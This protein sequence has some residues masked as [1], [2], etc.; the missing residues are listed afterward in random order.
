MKRMVLG[1]LCSALAMM[2]CQ[3]GGKV[4]GLT[5]ESVLAQ[6]SSFFQT[7]E[8]V[9]TGEVDAGPTVTMDELFDDFFFNYAGSCKMQMKRTN[10]PLHLSAFGT[11][12]A[13][14]EDEWQYEDFF[15]NDDAYTVF[16]NR[17]EDMELMDDTGR[18]SVEVQLIDATDSVLTTFHFDRQDGQWKLTRKTLSELMAMPM[19]GFYSFYRDFVAD[20]TFQRRSIARPLHYITYDEGEDD[21]SDKYIEGTL[22]PDQWFAFQ[23]DMPH[24]VLTN[25]LYGQQYP[26]PNRMVMLKRG[27]SNGLTNTFTFNRIDGKWKLTR[28][29]N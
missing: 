1:C 13:I 20:S 5:R 8:L 2:S 15:F 24:G 17:E 28:Y 25:I 7:D 16:F 12:S 27:V 6:D 9:L 22:T 11:D 26:N 3:N 23:P 21:D 10:F 14:E 4:R 19:A 18:N 29:E